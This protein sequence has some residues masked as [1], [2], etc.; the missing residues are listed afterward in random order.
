LIG[1]DKLR[2]FITFDFDL[3]TKQQIA[4]IQR[5]I[6]DNSNKGRFKYYN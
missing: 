3:K 5:I 6:K 1:G 2:T 4:N